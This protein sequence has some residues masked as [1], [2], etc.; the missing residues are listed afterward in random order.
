[1]TDSKYGVRLGKNEIFGRVQEYKL[2]KEKGLCRLQA[3]LGQVGY[4]TDEQNDALSQ[5][6]MRILRYTCSSPIVVI[7]VK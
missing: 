7:E 2:P 5:H 6:H 1:L 3:D 4:L